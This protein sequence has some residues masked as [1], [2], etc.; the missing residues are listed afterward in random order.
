VFYCV[1]RFLAF[2]LQSL[3][4]SLYSCQGFLPALYRSMAS[5]N[6]QGEI[7]LIELPNPGETQM[8]EGENESVRSGAAFF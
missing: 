6:S 3:R 1:S 4:V 5:L 8:W 2:E 7:V